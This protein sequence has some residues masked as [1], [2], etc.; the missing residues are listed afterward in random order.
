[1]WGRSSALTTALILAISD[2]R[3]TAERR[4]ESVANERDVCFSASD[5]W[6][7]R[8][9]LAD[10]S[11]SSALWTERVLWLLCARDVD[12]EEPWRWRHE[13]IVATNIWICRL[14]PGHPHVLLA[15]SAISNHPSLLSWL[16]ALRL[17]SLRSALAFVL[18]GLCVTF[19]GDQWL[20]R[21][22]EPLYQHLKDVYYCYFLKLSD[23]WKRSATSIG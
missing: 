17:L 23:G 2:A 21:V 18:L 5:W 6:S 20:M 4:R 14:D 16:S 15:L 13:L 22:Q 3:Q 11:Q 10:C 8:V 9:S 7:Q 19:S 1:M 12:T